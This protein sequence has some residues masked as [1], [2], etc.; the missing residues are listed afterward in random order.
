M[1]VILPGY[2]HHISDHQF[3]IEQHHLLAND[4]NPQL[5]QTHNNNHVYIS[6]TIHDEGINVSEIT[7]KVRLFYGSGCIE[8]AFIFT[9]AGAEMKQ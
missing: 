6:Y 8:E 1:E 5:F 3:F 9:S 4:N 7:E 2:I